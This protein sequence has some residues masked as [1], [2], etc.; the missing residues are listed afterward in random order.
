MIRAAVCAAALALAT[1]PAMAQVTPEEAR[2]IHD[3]ILVMDTHL[4]T[5]MLVAMPGFNI[6]NRHSF[7]RH[8]SQV[9]LPRMIEG[10]L[11]GGFWVI[12][13]PQGPR[14]EEGNAAALQAALAR[15]RAIHGMIEANPEHFE[16]ATHSSDAHRIAAAGRRVVYISIENSYPLSGRP[17]MVETFYD[18]GVRMIGPVHS[19]NNDF[20]DSTTDEPEWNGLSEAGRELVRE[21][22]RLGMILDASH[23]HDLAFDDMV[24]LSATPII[25]SHSGPRAVY[26]HPRNISDERLL[27]LAE[28]GGVIQMNALGAFLTELPPPSEERVAALR[29]L[30]QRFGPRGQMGPEE[31]AEWLEA[32]AEVNERHPAPRAT[33]EDFMDHLLHTLDLIGPDH[34]GIGADW[35]GGGGV[36]GMEDVSQIPRIT[37]R[38]LNEGYSEE[39][40]E[41]IWSGNVLRLLRAAEDHAAAL[42]AAEEGDGA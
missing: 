41:K 34:V 29:E 10:G 32:M 13:T 24:E 17:E 23:A 38:L 8:M 18:L 3:R 37:E 14:T 20:A 4:D 6:M 25:L 30:Q 36:A 26:D 11:D 7:A 21:A 19:R 5:P 2:A 22:N 28:T 1:A 35:D 12:Y 9:D 31:R 33:F 40:I 39:D 42:R 16:L 15:A 27:R